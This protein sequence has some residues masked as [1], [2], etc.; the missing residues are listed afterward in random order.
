MR[1]KMPSFPCLAFALALVLAAGP[2]SAVDF[3]WQGGGADDNWSTAGNWDA[4]PVSAADTGIIF[5]TA[6]A[7]TPNQDVGS[8]FVLNSLTVTAFEAA[9]LTLTGNQIQFA[10]ATPAF[11][12][13]AAVPV[14]I[15][16]AVDLSVDT[17]YTGGDSTISGIISGGGGLTVAA[18]GTLTLTGANTYSGGTTV[19]AGTLTG[20]ATSLQGDI[21][22]LAAVIFNQNVDGTYAGVISG[23]GTLEKTGLAGLTLSGAN[24]YSGGTTVTAGFL[25][26]DAASLQGGILNNA[27]VIFNQAA[28]GTYAGAMSGTGMLVKTGAGKLTLTGANTYS[29]DT[30]V[31]AGILEGDSTSLQGNIA[32][33]TAVIF[34]QAADGTY[35]GVL[36]GVGTLEKTGAGKLTLTGAN[37]YTGG[38][39]VTEGTLQGSATSLQGDIL[40]NA[41]VVFNQAVDGTYANVISGTGTFVKMG[42][43]T[44][45]LSGANTYLGTTGVIAGELQINGSIGAGLTSV[46]DGAAISGTGTIGGSV[47][48]SGII[49]PAGSVGTL[50]ISGDYDHAATAIYLVEFTPTAS[51][52]IDVAGNANIAGGEV[53]PIIIDPIENYESKTYT[54]LQAAA[55]VGTF[56]TFSAPPSTAV[57]SLELE[58]LPDR[59]DMVFARNSYASLGATP[60]QRSVAAALDSIRPGATGDLLAVLGTLDLLDLPALR[61]AL[62]DISPASYDA[63]STVSLNTAKLFSGGVVG[64]MGQVRSTMQ[65][66]RGGG[67]TPFDQLPRV[68][69]PAAAMTGPPMAPP[70]PTTQMPRGFSEV[71]EGRFGIWVRQFNTW[72]K[73]DSRG[74]AVGFDF[75]THGVMLGGDV[76]VGDNFVAGGAIGYSKT[77]ITLDRGVGDGDIEAIHALAYA[78]FFKD[79]WYIDGAL[80]FGY[81]SYDNTRNIKFLGRKADSEHDGQ[82]YLAYFGGGYDFNLGGWILGPI[83]S[84]QYVYLKEDAFTESGAGAM[85][86]SVDSRDS[87]SLQS[88]LGLRFAK[89]FD[90]TSLFA[91]VFDIDSVKLMPELR[92]EWLHEFL[93]GA[94]SVTSRFAAAGGSFTVQ[95]QEPGRDGAALGARLNMAFAK[96]VYVYVNYEL[97]LQ[98]GAGPTAHSLW[99]GLRVEF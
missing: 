18:A 78:T 1:P 26:G 91:E 34:N 85:S 86:M 52:L 58:Y 22:N 11:R 46:A 13:N 79:S 83:G 67:G 59:V 24:T 31:A 74:D 17:V 69:F 39:T 53:A 40:N 15:Q 41:A 7:A 68:A 20:N 50:S 97:L 84:L 65:L 77:G 45:T 14:D 44:L 33:D 76:L 64:R 95:G 71:R 28:D 42:A 51:D 55:V 30:A 56:D 48:N 10:G 61:A 92:A 38:T 35:A 23:A 93:Q 90:V 21:T 29:G 32:N 16:T 49:A 66:A 87:S 72:A 3:T 60:N 70:E 81:N 47:N 62:D 5:D 9:G 73:Q 94:G 25:E 96:N 88:A 12:N 19:A 43:G 99:A 80:G 75:N 6:L 63:T 37:V 89:V 82:E 8:P 54:I 2:L 27:T 36:G 57:L 98:G 4:P